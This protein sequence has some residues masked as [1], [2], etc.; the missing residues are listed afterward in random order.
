MVA[1]KFVVR[2]GRHPRAG[3]IF[4]GFKRLQPDL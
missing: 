2:D 3:E 4:E 1:G